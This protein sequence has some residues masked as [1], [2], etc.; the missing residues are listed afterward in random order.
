[1][2]IRLTPAIAVSQQISPEDCAVAR[3]EGYTAIV[4]NRPDGEVPGQPSAAMMRAA[5]EAA[6]LH[7]SDIPVDHTGMSMPQVE[8]MA[9]AMAAAGGPL[10][11]FCRSGTRSTNLWALAAAL[12]GDDPDAIVEAAAGGGYDVSGM[13]P[14]LQ[15]L[16][17][18][19]AVKP[20]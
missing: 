8:A 16:A 4:N 14:T 12:G 5:A 13:R 11:A 15:H 18:L 19:K 7:Y 2:F 20:A 9:A 10:L 6:G 1:M 17:G 3:G